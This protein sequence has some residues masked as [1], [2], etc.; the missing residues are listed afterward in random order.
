L[1]GLPSSFSCIAST[2]DPDCNRFSNFSIGANIFTKRDIVG[3]AAAG[4]LARSVDET[5]GHCTGNRRCAAPRQL[6]LTAPELFG[7]LRVMPLLK[8]FLQVQPK[9]PDAK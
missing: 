8:A 6:M 5:P 7:R 9:A 3:R 1:L 4:D 2:H